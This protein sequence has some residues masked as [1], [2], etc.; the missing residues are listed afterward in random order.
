[1]QDI[2]IIIR[3]WKEDD[4]R[5]SL[6]AEEQREL[7]ENPAGIVEVPQGIIN[8]PAAHIFGSRF[9]TSLYC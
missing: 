5:L 8:N 3:S 1:M 4:Y 9:I 7:P 6:S 2:E